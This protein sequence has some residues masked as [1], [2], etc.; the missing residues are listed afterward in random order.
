M[1]A[2]T[3]TLSGDQAEGA[4]PTGETVAWL[5]PGQERPELSHPRADSRPRRARPRG[6]ALEG[7]GFDPR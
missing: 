1:N 4:G 3:L 6:A 7:A 2:I 5:K